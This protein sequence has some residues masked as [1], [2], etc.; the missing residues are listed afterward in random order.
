MYPHTCENSKCQC[1]SKINQLSY[2]AIPL[3]PVAVPAYPVSVSSLVGRIDRSVFAPKIFPSDVPPRSVAKVVI[4]HA[5][6]VEI[7]RRKEPWKRETLKES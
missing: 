1:C 3:Q 7:L 4:F 6:G 2:T 5:E